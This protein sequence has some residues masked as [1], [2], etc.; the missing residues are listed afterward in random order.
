MVSLKIQKKGTDVPVTVVTKPGIAV[1][2]DTTIR[3]QQQPDSLIIGCGRNPGQKEYFYQQNFNAIVDRM[4]V[5]LGDD[6]STTGELFNFDP[7]DDSGALTSDYAGNWPGY[8]VSRL[9]GASPLNT[10]LSIAGGNTFRWQGTDG[11]LVI[12]D[13]GRPD[14]D[15]S[16]YLTAAGYIQTIKEKLDKLKEQ[17]ISTPSG[18]EVTTGESTAIVYGLHK[19]YQAMQRL[20]NYLVYRMSVILE[21]SF[22]S[23]AV[24]IQGRYINATDKNV[25]LSACTVSFT[26]DQASP[27]GIGGTLYPRIRSTSTQGV[28]PDWGT[29]LSV[30]DPTL[31]TPGESVV[32]R[33]ETM[34]EYT[35]VPRQEVS[36]TLRL[37]LAMASGG[38]PDAHATA[39]I[40]WQISPPAP[41][42]P[43]I[44]ISK[45]RTVFLYEED[46]S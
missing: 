33:V 40:A 43:E 19:Q 22:Q 34:T 5:A 23:D 21:V 31:F 6:G 29:T 1:V 7:S 12:D 44:V 9:S 15:C 17:I 30:G 16:D 13:I 8:Y 38:L 46:I 3:L 41:G 18:T 42:V 35:V 45:E 2:S 27:G 37:D 4:D 11:G 32:W 26:L 14:V 28:A 20:W 36:F 25:V 39:G 24:F 10:A